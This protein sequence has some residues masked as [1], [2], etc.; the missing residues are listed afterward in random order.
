MQILNIQNSNF[1]KNTFVLTLGTAIAQV[2]P[3][4]LYPALGRL[5]TPEQ[6][7]VLAAITSFVSIISTFVTGKYENAIFI[8]DTDKDAVCLFSVALVMSLSICF[9]LTIPLYVFS[10]SFTVY[11]GFSTLDSW[12]QICISASFFMA[13]FNIY[14][15]WCVRYEYFKRLSIN[16][17]VNSAGIS[18]FKLVFA[19]TNFANIGLV[20]GDWIGRFF[21]SVVCL[22]SIKQLDT[23]CFCDIQI[24]D[25]INV[26]RKYREYPMFNMPAQL[27]NSI[28]ISSPIFIL[29]YFYNQT[30]V[31]YYAMTMSVL[32]LP[33]NIISL[34]L[35][36]V[37]RKK[38][39]DILIV[40]GSFK[41][42][43]VKTLFILFVVTPILS[44]CVYPILPWL[45]K[46]VLGSQW[47]NS[48]VFAQYFIPMIALDF[49]AMSLSGS[50][51]VSK[52]L[53]YN[54]YWQVYYVILTIL[55]LY[56]AGTCSLN[57]SNT[58]IIYSIAR[59]SAYVLLIYISFKSSI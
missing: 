49:I 41:S 14:N 30:D 6:F 11:L 3:M 22:F 16:K 42:F 27:L 51:L 32:T 1:I 46:F 29:N 50:L 59:S 24:S 43:F 52:K 57:I 34:S 53:K 13:I 19:Y 35:R 54:F 10:D 15:E 8:A 39:S 18:L 33:V 28:G 23:S 56:I 31:G 9:I 4:L 36:D 21:S 37:F 47:G 7:A 2:L 12:I 58:L 25:I 44:I 17:I 26:L 20:A 45:F 48:G 5:Y 40:E 38:A 55:T